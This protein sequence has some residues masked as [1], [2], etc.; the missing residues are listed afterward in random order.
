MN[1]NPTE[2][3][4]PT[5]LPAQNDMSLPVYIKEVQKQ[6]QKASN[7]PPEM[8][9]DEPEMKTNPITETK[10]IPLQEIPK[11][12]IEIQDEEA[13][14][15]EDAGKYKVIPSGSAIF[16]LVLKPQY[17]LK[18]ISN[19]KNVR[20]QWFYITT[21]YAES[22]VLDK[23]KDFILQKYMCNEDVKIDNDDYYQDININYVEI[24]PTDK[25][26]N[27]G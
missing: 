7:N 4:T 11:Q 24:Q 18:A 6:A 1:Y 10:D 9:Y 13:P 22:E 15:I 26:A 21:R 5:A 14:D 25:S 27:V 3:P 12:E 20:G 16:R 2:L 8:S 17:T 23:W 19:D